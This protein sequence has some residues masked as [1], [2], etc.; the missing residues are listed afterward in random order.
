M[1]INP[2]STEDNT[3]KTTKKKHL[4]SVILEV[5]IIAGWALFIG[6]PYLNFNPTV[7]PAGDEFIMS[8]QN[9]YNLEQL[10]K[11]GTCFF[12]NGSTNGGVPSFV[13]IHGAW[14]HPIS[15]ISTFLLGAFNGGKLIFILSIFMAG[16]AQWW[17][18]KLLKLGT[19]PR[20]WGALLV[21]AGG[22]LAGRMAIGSMP[23]ILS[24]A[25][26]S[27]AIPAAWQLAHKWNWKNAI[28]LGITLG[29]AA[30]SGQGYMQ[31]GL[32]VCLIPS[33][34]YLMIKNS[35]TETIKKPKWKELVIVLVV[36]FLIAAVLLVPL[37]RNSTFLYKDTDLQFRSAQPLKYSLLNLVIDDEVYYRTEIMGKLSI[38]YLY[39]NYIGWI[40]I[41][42]AFIGILMAHREYRKYFISFG[43]AIAA[44][45]LTS[46]GLVLQWIISLPFK[47]LSNAV[48]GFRNPT[49]IQG[50]T[51]PFIVAFSSVGL[52][53][54][55][56]KERSTFTVSLQQ[57]NQGF[58]QMT[59]PVKWILLA[60]V[61]ILSLRSLV[62]FSKLYVYTFREDGTY[63]QSVL[64][65]LKT[66]DT[67]WVQPPFGEY[68]WLPVALENNMKIRAYFRP[69]NVNGEELPAAY[70]NMSRILEDANLPGFQKMVG[71]IVLLAHPEFPYAYIAVGQ[72]NVPCTANSKGGNIDVVCDALSGGTLVVMERG[73]PGW[74]VWVDGS[75]TALIDNTWLKTQALPGSH[76]Y[77]FRYRPWDV[78]LGLALSLLG[79]LACLFGFWYLR[80]HPDTSTEH[81]VTTAV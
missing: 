62:I 15:I 19:L 13:D 39:T 34:G 33:I 14:L 56:K 65:S 29:M 76:T 61:M 35:R 38:P 78:Y 40:P 17:L 48:A 43:L 36:A 51:I 20:L 37:L 55:I 4:L 24:T 45:F 9:N 66:P 49:L 22:H 80:R 46:S 47:E 31:I 32:I 10:L 12:W 71:D 23:I 59:I 70:L 6:R 42:F 57:T 81:V 64:D 5:G 53:C 8:L 52:E 16:M 60:A 21:V 44:I 67:Q 25:A 26:C 58:S 69:W 50:L 73:L 27:L 54:L 3:P 41:L 11:C 7:W 63:I 74:K 68:Y 1:L 79:W 18:S 72:T 77:L 30:L 75:K 2:A 28:I